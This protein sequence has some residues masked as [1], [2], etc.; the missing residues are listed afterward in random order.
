MWG[1]ELLDTNENVTFQ[2]LQPRIYCL[3]MILNLCE[4]PPV[5]GMEITV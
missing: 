2:L 3:N 5:A 1:I 4:P